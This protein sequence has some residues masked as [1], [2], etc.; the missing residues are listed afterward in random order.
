MGQQEEESPVF[1]EVKKLSPELEMAPTTM[2]SKCT[3]PSPPPHMSNESSTPS[4]ALTIPLD[5]SNYDDNQDLILQRQSPRQLEN[6]RTHSLA[7]DTVW[8]QRDKE[9]K[10]KSWALFVVCTIVPFVLFPFAFGGFDKIMVRMAGTHARPTLY[11]KSLAKYL[12]V[13]EFVAWPSLVA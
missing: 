10:R 8:L 7:N 3:D 4:L 13:V 5:I 1:G 2:P 6:V 11:Q 9:G 12:C